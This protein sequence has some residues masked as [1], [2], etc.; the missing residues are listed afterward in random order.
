[1]LW[2]PDL[3]GVIRIVTG[4]TVSSRDS[5]NVTVVFGILD[6]SFVVSR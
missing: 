5:F 4:I 1:M 2:D 6:T 3:C